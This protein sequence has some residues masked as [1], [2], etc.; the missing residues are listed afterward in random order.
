M[1]NRQREIRDILRQQ[2]ASGL[3]RG[4]L[5]PGQ[6]LPS[7]RRIGQELRATPRTVMAAYAGLAAQGVVELR[8]RSGS[9]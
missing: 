1:T 8:Q 4:S 6:R 3:H 9:Y 2:I 7:T 5:A